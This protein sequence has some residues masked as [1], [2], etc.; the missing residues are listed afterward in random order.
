MSSVDLAGIVQALF[1]GDRGLLAM[2]ESVETCN[3]RFA[4]VGIAPTLENRPAYRD[5]IIRTPK[6]NEAI[7]GAILF[8]E[9]SAKLQLMANLSVIWQQLQ[10]LFPELRWIWVLSPLRCIQKKK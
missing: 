4:E 9:R 6:L 1:A 3:K 2:D 5:W 8:D 7:G 10:G